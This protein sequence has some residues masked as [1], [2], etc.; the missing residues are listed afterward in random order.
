MPTSDPSTW[1]LPH[2]GI[3]RDAAWLH[4]G[5]EVTHAGI[6]AALWSGLRVDAAGHYLQIGPLRVPVEVEDAPFVVL[7]VEDEGDR[8]MLTLSDLGR[9]PLAPDALRFAPGGVP[10][11][12][13]KDGRF[14]ARLSRAA[15]YQLLRHVEPDVDQDSATL[16]IGGAR[17]RLPGLAGD[18]PGGDSA[19]TA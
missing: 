9:E 3:T 17:Y 2:L 8:L 19:A 18:L 4:D 11:C 1:K 15:T 5:E 12:R 10:Y 6:L 16:V 7:R 14:D 13:V